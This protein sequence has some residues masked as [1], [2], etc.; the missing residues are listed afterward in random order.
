[1]RELGALILRD[2]TRGNFSLKG[3]HEIYVHVFQ[4][5]FDKGLDLCYIATDRSK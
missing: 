1:M 2:E 4:S 3:G 5:Y